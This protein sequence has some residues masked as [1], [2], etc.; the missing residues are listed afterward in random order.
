MAESMVL[1]PLDSASCID[2]PYCASTSSSLSPRYVPSATEDTFSPV[3]DVRKKS[4]ASWGHRC[5]KR[6]VPAALARVTIVRGDSGNLTGGG[7]FFIFRT[8]IQ[9]GTLLQE[10]PRP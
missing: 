10:R 4:G 8:L 3:R 5:A 9:A 6:S 1:M 7:G 2:S